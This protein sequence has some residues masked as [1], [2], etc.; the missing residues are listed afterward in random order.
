MSISE[1]GEYIV[2]GSYNEKVYLFGKDSSTPLWSYSTN[3]IVYAVALSADGE[4]IV[5]GSYDGGKA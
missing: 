5:A 1:D 2:A 3:G 4:Y